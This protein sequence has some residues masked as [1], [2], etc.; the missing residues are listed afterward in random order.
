MPVSDMGLHPFS[1]ERMVAAVDAVKERVRR[2]ATALGNASVPYAVVGGHAVAAWVARVDIEAVRNT[3]DVD[4]LIDRADLPRVREIL[5]SAG[6]LYRQVNGVDLFLD[7]PDGSVRSAVHLVFA[8]ERVRAG[9]LM[10]A[11]DVGESEEGPEFAIVT[12]DALVRMKL[13]AFRL[14]D[15]VHLVDLLEV[16]LIDA[17]WPSRLPAGLGKRLEELLTS[18]EEEA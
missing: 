9:H 3:K 7:G 8:G 5:E 18:L 1:W 4:I 11:P 17:S 15:K 12:L 10:A 14:K 2:V 6:F 16:G 13:T